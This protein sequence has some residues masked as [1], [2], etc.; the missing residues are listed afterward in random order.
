MQSAGKCT[1]VRKMSP[2]KEYEVSQ[3]QHEPRSRDHIRDV[4]HRLRMMPISS[5]VLI[6]NAIVVVTGAVAGTWLTA[7]FVGRDFGRNGAWLMLVFAAIGVFLSVLVNYRILKAAFE[8]LEKLERVAEAVRMGDFSARTD[9]ARFGDPQLERFGQS[10]NRALNVIEQDR[11][12]IRQLADRVIDA[13]EQERKRIARE[14][15]DDTAQLLFAQLLRVSALASSPHPEV[16]ETA[17]EIGEMMSAAM[18]NVRR[19][20]HELRPPALDDLGVRAALEDLAQRMSDQMGIP[21]TFRMTEFRRR[22]D[23]GVEL[24]L[25]RVAQEAITNTWKHAKATRVDAEIVRNEDSVTMVIVDDGVGFNASTAGSSDGR[26]LGMGL[27][28]MAERVE[29]VGGTLTVDGSGQPGTRVTA[30]IPLEQAHQ[31]AHPNFL[32]GRDTGT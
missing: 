21:V 32:K 26:G 25:Y 3:D 13:Q 8:P 5:K 23:P 9:A 12:Q 24:V 18:E 17:E 29:L 2:A 28:G 14:L 6:A 27:F 1:K 4:R 19:L 15:H 16:R 31:I 10:F 11:E 22:V 20:G 30:F 7:T